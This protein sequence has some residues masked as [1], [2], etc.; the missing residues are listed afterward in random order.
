MKYCLCIY[1][2]GESSGYVTYKPMASRKQEDGLMEE[3]VDEYFDKGNSDET[4]TVITE[5]VKIRDCTRPSKTTVFCMVIR[6]GNKGKVCLYNGK[7]HN[8]CELMDMDTLTDT[9][10]L[11]CDVVDLPVWDFNNEKWVA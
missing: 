3:A 7:S 8:T 4:V 11:H 1:V 6:G 2:Q 5:R 10:A 9:S